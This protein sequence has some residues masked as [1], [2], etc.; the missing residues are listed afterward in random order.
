MP[1]QEKIIDMRRLLYAKSQQI[2][3]NIGYVLGTRRWSDVSLM[4]VHRLRRCPSI[5]TLLGQRVLGTF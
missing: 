3:L 2:R 1:T 5:K 4:W